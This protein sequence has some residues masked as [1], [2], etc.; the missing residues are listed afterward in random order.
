MVCMKVYS[1]ICCIL[2]MYSDVAYCTVGG[3]LSGDQPSKLKHCYSG[4][5]T[6]ALGTIESIGM[7]LFGVSTTIGLALSCIIYM[8]RKDPIY[9]SITL[10]IMVMLIVSA[11][12][13][14]SINA[15]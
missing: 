3:L 13:I 14:I 5:V 1:C 11:L 9:V 10:M 4:V 12:G 8:L 7:T 15:G 2:I 6:S